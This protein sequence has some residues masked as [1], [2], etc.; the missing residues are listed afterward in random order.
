MCRQKR[1]LPSSPAWDASPHTVSGT[2]Q[3]C[4]YFLKNHWLNTD[5][6]A[7]VVKL[8]SYN[9]RTNLK[10]RC[11]LL[12]RREKIRRARNHL[13]YL[14][15]E[16]LVFPSSEMYEQ[17]IKQREHQLYVSIFIIDKNCFLSPQEHWLKIARP[18]SKIVGILNKSNL[19]IV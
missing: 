15:L 10:T 12:S 16:T 17:P 18:T 13:F 1:S 8:D 5:P 2:M 14:V 6:F 4:F 19:A 11:L 3:Q 7:A 9:G